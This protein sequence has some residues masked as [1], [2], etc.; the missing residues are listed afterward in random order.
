MQ[1]TMSVLFAALVLFGCYAVHAHCAPVPAEAVQ[2]PTPAPTTQDTPMP[3][4]EPTAISEP[5]LPIA[6]GGSEA[7]ENIRVLCAG[8]VYNVRLQDYLVGCVAAEMP[9]SFEYEALKAQAVAA[10]SFALYS[11]NVRRHAE[12]D[13]CTSS[14]CCQAWLGE[15]ALRTSW[16]ERFDENYSRVC[17]AVYD[18]DGEYLVYDGSP[19]F[20][21]FHASSPGATADCGRVW[22]PVP[23]LV[24]VFSPETP[25]TVPEL[26]SAVELSALDFRDT[27]LHERPEADFTGGEADWVQNIERDESG[28]VSRAVI[29]G[30]EFSGTRLRSLFSLRSSCF[31]LEYTGRSF[32]FTVSGFGHGVGMS[33]HG[34]NL[35]AADGADYREILAHYYPGTELA[36]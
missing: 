32:L 31:T 4:A 2:A 5:A 9:A 3:A 25:E 27:L 14:A 28:R 22:N 16:G 34:A 19:A 6:E 1:K 12:A 26:I 8:E 18:T 23:Y 15:Q 36:G 29:G 24:S 10:R 33:Q 7:P 35:M 30:A 21:A 20:A 13:V 17:A 11:A